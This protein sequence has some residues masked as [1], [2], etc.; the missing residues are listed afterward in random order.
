M[1]ILRLAEHFLRQ[2]SE[3]LG[4]SIEGIERSAAQKLLDY[5]WPGNVRELSNYI[6][7][8]ATLT[9]ANQIRVIDLP[10]K[11]RRF[12]VTG[13][14]AQESIPQTVITLQELQERYIESVLKRVQGNKTQAAKL[15]GLDRR[16]LYRKLER[17]NKSNNGSAELS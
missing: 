9:S 15:L 13:M 6:E 1:D 4:R 16:T 5:D 11:V 2:Y 10:E 12:E 3:R 8:A 7:R 14:P 17:Y